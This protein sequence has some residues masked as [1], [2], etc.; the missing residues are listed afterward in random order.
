MK[1][2]YDAATNGLVWISDQDGVLAHWDYT[3]REVTY[4]LKND[5][6]KGYYEQPT[7]DLFTGLEPALKAEVQSRMDIPGF[8]KDIPPI[9][10]GAAALNK[11]VDKYGINVRICTAPWGTNPTCTDDK[12]AW[13][14]K[15]IGEGWRRRT[16]TATDKT[17]IRGSILIDD[18]P[19]VTGD[20]EPEFEHV[21][22]TQRYNVG[23]PGRRIDSWDEWEDVLIAPL[24]SAAAA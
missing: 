17:F 16:I 14:D 20:L 2:V 21:Y 19:Y 18:K 10:G 4:D 23:L 5:L 24:L 22:F 3:F 12:L 11:M 13:I 1:L 6:P 9:P 7:F 8:Y 15:H